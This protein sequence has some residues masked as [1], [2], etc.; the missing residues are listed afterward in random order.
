MKELVEL[1]NRLSEFLQIA[2]M[3]IK[4]IKGTRGKLS[5]EDQE[6]IGRALRAAKDRYIVN[7]LIASVKADNTLENFDI[8]NKDYL[9]RC[10]DK[11]TQ[12]ET[13]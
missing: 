5:P 9:G 7:V 4:D 3:A 10:I 13:D 2:H 1:E 6:E 8:S 12:E 11:C